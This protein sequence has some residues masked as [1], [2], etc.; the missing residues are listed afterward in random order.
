[1]VNLWIG[2][3]NY[4]LFNLFYNI[5]KYFNTL[6]N[7]KLLMIIIKNC[8]FCLYLHFRTV[9]MLYAIHALNILN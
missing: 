6:S 2:T 7:Y 3:Y 9:K 5:L 4:K 1:M 8:Y